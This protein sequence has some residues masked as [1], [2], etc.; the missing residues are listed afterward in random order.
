MLGGHPL[1]QKARIFKG[2]AAILKIAP[3]SENQ[4]AA[5]KQEG[6]SLLPVLVSPDEFGTFCKEKRID[7]NNP[8]CAQFA[9]SRGPL[10]TP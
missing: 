10:V 8:N 3:Q 6:I 5:K 2:Y 1:R 9:S 7:C 4:R